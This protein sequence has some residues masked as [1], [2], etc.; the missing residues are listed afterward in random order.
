L[1]NID[2]GVHR[3]YRLGYIKCVIILGEVIRIFVVIVVW[4]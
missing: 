4:G 1:Y 3:L 2:V